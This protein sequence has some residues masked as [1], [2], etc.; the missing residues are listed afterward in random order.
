M[1]RTPDYTEYSDEELLE[2]MRDLVDEPKSAWGHVNADAILVEA[3]RRQASRDGGTAEEW[4]VASLL[5][6]YRNVGKWYA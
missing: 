6:A 3:L 1:S 4:W 2:Q 5:D